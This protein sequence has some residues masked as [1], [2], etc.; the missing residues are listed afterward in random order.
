MSVLIL[1]SA[2]EDA[3]P[4]PAKEVV[5]S[6]KTIGERLR[7]IRRERGMTQAELAEVIG[8]HFTSISQIERGL[9]GLTI[10][11]LVKL[12][13]ALGVSPNEVLLDG[14]KTSERI[15]RRRSRLLRRLQRIE[16]L[17]LSEQ[18]AILKILD[19]LLDRDGRA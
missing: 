19:G 2:R 12:T 14:K 5:L 8:T 1:F 17:P 4:R 11:Q 13:R 15:S 7:T 18:R 10:Q 6:N 3:L 9:R 16:E